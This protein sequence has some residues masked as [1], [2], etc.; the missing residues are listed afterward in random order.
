MI[1]LQ[2][3]VYIHLNLSLALAAAMSKKQQV[4]HYPKVQTTLII[5]THRLQTAYL[6]KLYPLKYNPQWN[7]RRQ[8]NQWGNRVK[9]LFSDNR[10]LI[11]TREKL[12]SYIQMRT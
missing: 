6:I 4:T 2:S 9:G 1:S 11:Y 5:I 7:K 10:Y 8:L 3:L 12:I